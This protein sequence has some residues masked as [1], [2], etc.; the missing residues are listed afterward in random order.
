MLSEDEYGRLFGF[1]RF[2]LESTQWSTVRK[3]VINYLEQRFK[4][5]KIETRIGW[6]VALGIV[7]ARRGVSTKEE[8][9]RRYIKVIVNL[10]RSEFSYILNGLQDFMLVNVSNIWVQGDVRSIFPTCP[11]CT[12]ALANRDKPVRILDCGHMFHEDEIAEWIR[13][14]AARPRQGGQPQPVPACP[15]CRRPIHEER[16]D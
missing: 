12:N 13:T 8:F 10:F 6:E 11:I 2:D 3:N 4:E 7:S 15:V 9:I 16:A 5:M 1:W 14:V